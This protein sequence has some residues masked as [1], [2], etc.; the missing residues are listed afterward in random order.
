MD[1]L[2]WEKKMVGELTLKGFEQ[3]QDLG[4]RLFECNNRLFNLGCCYYSII[5]LKDELGSC[6][7][8]SF[9][10]ESSTKSRAMMSTIGLIMGMCP[11][12]YET[13]LKDVF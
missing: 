7:N 10:L 12:N 2:F 8:R 3:V 13:I 5:I 6:T 9:Y 1:E 4:Y 11:M